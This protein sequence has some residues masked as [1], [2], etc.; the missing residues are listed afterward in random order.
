MIQRPI[1]PQFNDAIDRDGKITTIRE[2]P[3]P[4]GIPIQLYNWTGRPYNSP[5]RK[6]A[7]V[8]VIETRPIIIENVGNGNPLRFDY[9]PCVLGRLLWQTE[10]FKSAYALDDW[11]RKFVPRPDDRIER[12]LMWFKR[13]QNPSPSLPGME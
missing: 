13:I 5:Q 9:G 7:I 6:T 3:W 1:R 4:I 2:K 12:S 10:G 8:E 11:F